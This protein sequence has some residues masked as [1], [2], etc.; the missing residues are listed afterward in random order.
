MNAVL[1][2]RDFSPGVAQF[3]HHGF[4]VIDTAPL[5]HHIAAGSGHR[6]QKGAGLDAVC[7]H[8]VRAAVQLLHALDANAAG[9]VSLNAGA[10]FDQHLGQ[11]G[12]LG[13][14]GGVLQN[15]FAFSQGRS[16]QE[17]LGP[18]DGD[19]VG[20]DARAFQAGP[21]LGQF[22]NHVAMLHPNLGTHGTQSFDVLIH[23]ARTDRATTGQGHRGLTKSCQQ[24]PQSQDRC[25]HGFDQLIGSFGRCERP[26]IDLHTAWVRL[27][28][29]HTHVANQLEHSGHILQARD[30]GERHGVCRQQAGTELRQGCVLG[31]RDGH[32]ANQFPAPANQ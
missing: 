24:G 7:H 22:G 5:Q 14:L 4:Q 30:I 25:P 28:D 20:G 27:L 9:A 13:F 2:R 16:H 15:G 26:R 10:H 17:V 8:L 18:R 6:A 21:A 29:T 1:H 31:A 3:L 32:G 12:N 23:G 19:H 11:V